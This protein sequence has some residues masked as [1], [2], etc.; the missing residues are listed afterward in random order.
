[1]LLRFL[2]LLSTVLIYFAV[3][4]G[5][6]A[7]GT[8]QSWSVNV[9]NTVGYSLGILW[10]VK[11]VMR[12]FVRDKPPRWVTT[13]D[14]TIRVL[15][16]STLLVLLY[17]LISAANARAT[18]FPQNWEFQYHS[19]IFWL[20]HSYD[21]GSSW[22]MF[23]QNLGLAGL[24]WAL[25]DW[26]LAMTPSEAEAHS[27]SANTLE[28]GNLRLSDRLR[29]LLWVLA[30][31]G[32]LLAIQ[33]IL[34]RLGG[35][36][37]LLWMATPRKDTVGGAGVLTEFG[38]WPYRANASQYFNLL[39]PVILGFC[40]TE[41]NFCRYSVRA[42]ANS[43]AALGLLIGVIFMAVCPLVATSRTGAGVLVLNLG[44]AAIILW[45]ASQKHEALRTRLIIPIVTLIIIVGG[46]LLG[47]SSLAPRLGTL[48]VD[49]QGRQTL[50]QVGWE[51]AT[52]NLV[53]G[54]GP[55][56]LETIYQ[57]YMHNRT[58]FWPAQLHNDWME[59]LATFGCVGFA[60]I[61]LC[62]LLAASHCLFGQGIPG[63]K[64][65]VRLAWIAL[66]GC[67]LHAR[68]D[69]PFE[70]HSVLTLFLVICAILSCV[71]LTAA[72]K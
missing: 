68:F 37:K 63:E 29:S 20:P 33:G 25:R 34:Q 12:P 32:A 64:H 4:F 26:L 17:N 54:T 47:W 9:M 56:S 30:V 14:L 2:D 21:S 38:A 18:Y 49:A 59:I 52:D 7:F 72:S 3:V 62:L 45:F 66:A 61:F 35:G 40:W 1:M 22:K 36:S 53:F 11:L 19:V 24:F 42:R 60:L 55:G 48:S 10:L 31:S 13:S 23:W 16:V 39:W 41:F 43:K 46:G 27:Y 15:A 44:L 5:P 28:S 8:T 67:L 71:S 50:S 6:W 69:W 70:C 51:I 65:F 57:L 58:D